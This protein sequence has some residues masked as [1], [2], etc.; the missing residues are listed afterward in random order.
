MRL[1]FHKAVGVRLWLAAA[2]LALGAC[3][4]VNL[5][6]AP[7][8]IGEPVKPNPHYKVGAPYVVDDR[9]Y[10]PKV[11]EQYDEIGV[12]SWYGDEF[13]GKLTANG[14]IFDKRRLS[15]AHKT[16]PM[17]TLVQVDNLENGRSILVRVNDRGPFKGDRIIDLSHAAADELGF[18]ATGLARVRVRYVGE[19]SLADLAP[20]PGERTPA[21]APALASAERRDDPMATLIA[22]SSGASQPAGRGGEAEKIWVE[23]TRV[24]D[25]SA[26]SRMR[27]DLPEL[28]PVTVQAAES[29][30]KRFQSLRVGPYIDE[31]MALASLSRV[32]AAGFSGAQLVRSAGF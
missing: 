30:G 6:D 23:L 10:A 3:S 25:L 16:L 2:L 31:T 14:E 4:T 11:D 18:A 5:P 22:R 32:R 13:H 19:T 1:T 17:P 26:L 20:L 21:L 15:A 8:T 24:E 29:M 28:G 7:K 12:A 9:W 27:L